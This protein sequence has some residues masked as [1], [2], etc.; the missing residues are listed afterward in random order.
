MSDDPQVRPEQAAEPDD[1]LPPPAAETLS[2]P[3]SG[4]SPDPPGPEDQPASGDD[5]RDGG[6]HYVP[7]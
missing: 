1:E 2:L 3:P 6:R 5:R 7:L 4:A